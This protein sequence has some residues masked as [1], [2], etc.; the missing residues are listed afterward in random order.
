[1]QAD[2]YIDKAKITTPLKMVMLFQQYLHLTNTL[3]K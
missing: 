1:M 2:H 3:S